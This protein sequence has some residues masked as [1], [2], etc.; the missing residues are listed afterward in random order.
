MI[1]DDDDDDVDEDVNVT[2]FDISSMDAC[3][4]NPIAD[5]LLLE[6]NEGLWLS[7]IMFCCMFSGIILAAGCSAAAGAAVGTKNFGLGLVFGGLMI[8]TEGDWNKLV[9]LPPPWLKVSTYLAR[10]P[11]LP[12]AENWFEVAGIGGIPDVLLAGVGLA[13]STLPLLKDSVL[14]ALFKL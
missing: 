3:F 14:K 5:G 6:E 10:T 4:G 7:G 2:L 12:R 1:N 9:G 8:E 11:V 13:N